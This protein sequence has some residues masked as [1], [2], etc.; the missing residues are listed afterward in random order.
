MLNQT[1]LHQKTR[2]DGGQDAQ[3]NNPEQ[4]AKIKNILVINFRYNTRFDRSV[5]PRVYCKIS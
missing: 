1:N 3:I 4:R 2:I 5:I